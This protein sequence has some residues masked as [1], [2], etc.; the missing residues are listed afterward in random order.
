MQRKEET[1]NET[2]LDVLGILAGFIL[3]V[4]GGVIVKIIVAI[5]LIIE[6]IVELALVKF[7]KDEIMLKAPKIIFGIV[8]LICSIGVFDVLFKIVGVVVLV[9]SLGYLG[10]NYYLYKR[11]GV[12]IIK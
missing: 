6:P 4:T 12:K 5:Y 8:L 1:S 3:L 10:C 2:L 9:A 11:S 7:E